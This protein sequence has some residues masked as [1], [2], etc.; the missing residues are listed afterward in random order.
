[1][2]FL[3][4]SSYKSELNDNNKKKNRINLSDLELKTR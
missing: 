2:K 4:E 1:M 3:I